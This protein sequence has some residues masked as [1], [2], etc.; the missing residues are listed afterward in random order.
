MLGPVHPAS[1]RGAG[2]DGIRQMKLSARAVIATV[3][4]ILAAAGAGFYFL[5]ESR[6]P[7]NVVL[8]YGD[9]DLREKGF[10]HGVS[11][12]VRRDLFTPGWTVYRRIAVVQ[13]TAFGLCRVSDA[14][15]KI[16]QQ[17]GDRLRTGNHT[18]AAPRPGFPSNTLKRRRN[19]AGTPTGVGARPSRTRNGP[20]AA[21]SRGADSVHRD[22]VFCRAIGLKGAV[23]LD[24]VAPR[25]R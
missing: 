25:A 24:V 21:G 18:A 15:C 9:V 6:A 22:C 1:V 4:L 10:R 8:L 11:C 20:P 7:A 5:R 12:V 16:F 14:A 19:F 3:L 13:E 17:E 23:I 2:T